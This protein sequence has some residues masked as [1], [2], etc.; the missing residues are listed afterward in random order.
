MTVLKK[1]VIKAYDAAEHK[2]TV[3]IA[4]SLGVWLE[5]LRVATNI[6]AADVVAG[7]QCAVLF[8]DPSNQ[9][10]AVV[11]T[12]HGDL[13]SVGDILAAR[14]TADLTLTTTLQ[15]ITGDGDSNKV[16]ILLPTSGDWLIEATIDVGQNGANSP[17]ALTAA[18]FV[19]DSETYETGV[20][21]FTPTANGQRAT[22]A[23]RWQVT[24][25]AADTPIE[26]RAKMDTAGGNGI[27]RSPH[28]ALTATGVQRPTGGGGVSDHGDL[29]GLGDDDHPQYGAL[30]HSETVAALWT[31]AAGIKLAA[32]QAIH[33]AGG[34][35]RLTVS[36]ST[37]NLRLLGALSMQGYTLYGTT[38]QWGTLTLDSTSHAD[39]GSVIVG[40]DALK[41]LSDAIKD[42]SGATRI[43]FSPWAPNVSVTGNFYADQWYGE[44][45]LNRTNAYEPAL[46]VNKGDSDAKASFQVRP[47]DA[48]GSAGRWILG[49]GPPE[50]T[51]D[52]F[53]WRLAPNT[54]TLAADGGTQPRLLIGAN[55][56]PAA[57]A[58]L[59]LQSTIG[60]L[61]LTRMTT[62]QR[63]AL[64]P[65][66]G[67]VIYNTTT[68]Q[69]EGRADG[70]WVAL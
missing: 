52:A 33:D 53:L 34:N 29:T 12:V 62:A 38:D 1:A 54:L 36:L 11:I 65:A 70:A 3:Q 16:R 66:D 28:T 9:D 37:P 42:S 47:G 40:G 17:G 19:N 24:T 56:A 67:M 41:L 26:L 6:P 25:T 51:M 49:F 15:S 18:L 58:L 64:T 57:S 4:G 43:A 21:V 7:R 46:S 45:R 59:E 68:A 14:A 39:K 50:D 2:A 10:D 23:Q 22:V 60:A 63:D 32:N 35:P 48:T 5:S 27:L 69:F 30:A 55:A 8:L 44:Q 31:F 61:L 13:P 20:A